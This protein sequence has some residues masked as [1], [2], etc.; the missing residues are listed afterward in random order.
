MSGQ[1]TVTVNTEEVS[2]DFQ[3]FRVIDGSGQ[4]VDPGASV[5]VQCQGVNLNSGEV[6]D[7]SWDRGEPAT[8]PTSGV[9]PGFRDGL[10]VQNVGSWVLVI[11]PPALGYGPSGGTG[12]GRIVPDNNIFFVVDVMGVL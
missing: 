3:M 5:I 12:D 2:R 4:E 6:F 10:V 1:P 11:I 9:L 7:S 8:F